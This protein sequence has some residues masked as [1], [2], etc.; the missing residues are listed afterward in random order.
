MEEEGEGE[1]RRRREKN[2][3]GQLER[4]PRPSTA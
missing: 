3:V 2:K 1:G 4:T